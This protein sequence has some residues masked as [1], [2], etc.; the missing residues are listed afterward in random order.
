MSEAW[1]KAKEFK[2]NHSWRKEDLMKTG[3]PSPY[4]IDMKLRKQEFEEGEFY[5]NSYIPESLLGPELYGIRATWE[6]GLRFGGGI[7]PTINQIRHKIPAFAKKYNL[8]MKEGALGEYGIHE[9]W[10]ENSSGDRVALIRD[11]YFATS[12]SEL[13]RKMGK[14]IYFLWDHW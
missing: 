1:K 2:E 8:E 14:E 5:V 6:R 10:L 4:A 3:E 13:F 7:A 9:V 11:Q 12:T